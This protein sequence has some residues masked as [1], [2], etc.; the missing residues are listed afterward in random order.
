MI[1]FGAA[2]QTHRP[3]EI[4]SFIG[5]PFGS[6]AVASSQTAGGKLMPKIRLLV[7]VFSDLVG[8]N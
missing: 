4:P 3:A 8:A 1:C 2:I 5:S 7:V 6:A